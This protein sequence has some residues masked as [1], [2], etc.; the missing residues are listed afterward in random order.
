MVAKKELMSVAS[1]GRKTV[2]E[3]E[4]EMELNLVVERVAE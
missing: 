3:R 2:A 4:G 1:S